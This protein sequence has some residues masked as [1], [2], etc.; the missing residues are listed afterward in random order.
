[1]QGRLRRKLL[2]LKIERWIAHTL[3]KD[4]FD[5]PVNES[6]RLFSL[7]ISRK[8]PRWKATIGLEEDDKI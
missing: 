2:V 3:K 1:M 5:V 8:N 7:D 4:V 6:E